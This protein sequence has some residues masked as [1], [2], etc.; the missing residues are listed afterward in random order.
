M[1]IKRKVISI[2]SVWLVAATMLA[3]TA[4]AAWTT[5]GVD[6]IRQEKSNWCWAASLEMCATYLGY[7]DYDQWDIVREVKG[8]TSNPYPNNTGNAS[9]YRDGMEFATGD[10]YTASRTGTVFTINELDSFMDDMMP[11]IFTIGTYNSSGTRTSGH[12]VV[13][14]AVDVTANKVK[15]RDPGSDNPVTKYYPTFTNSAN[16]T[17]CDGSVEIIQN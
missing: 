2:L 4:Y 6:I 10:D 1:Y 16:T 3:T 17:Y 9:N 5:L 8:T 7:T 14:Y 13:C 12:A 11:V 15:Y